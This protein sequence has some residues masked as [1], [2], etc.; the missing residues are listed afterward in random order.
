MEEGGIFELS[1]T[2]IGDMGGLSSY[3]DN[4]IGFYIHT[5]IR[6][7]NQENPSESGDKQE[8]TKT[9]L[10][11]QRSTVKDILI[12]PNN[13][14][15]LT[16]EIEIPRYERYDAFSV[17]WDV[18]LKCLQDKME[19]QK[20][21]LLALKI[22]LRSNRG[23]DRKVQ[24]SILRKI[25]HNGLWNCGLSYESLEWICFPDENVKFTDIMGHPGDILINT[26]ALASTKFLILHNYNP[27]Y[28]SILIKPSPGS[29]ESCLNEI[30]I[31]GPDYKNISYILFGPYESWKALSHN[32]IG[33]PPGVYWVDNSEKSTRMYPVPH[34]YKR[35]GLLYLVM[36][37]Q[38]ATKGYLESGNPTKIL[39]YCCLQ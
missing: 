20:C 1:S 13:T 7:T 12:N 19:G 31:K 17:T 16:L 28:K 27:E 2:T 37:I 10:F 23:W 8:Q 32:G 38:N 9:V 34:Y 36:D 14:S 24:K 18:F 15:A 30:I 4:N 39:E 29:N 5:T 3:S 22:T 11:T 26:V 21:T 25:N 35:S 33:E 6:E